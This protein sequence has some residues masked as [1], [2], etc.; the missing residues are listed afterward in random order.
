MRVVREGGTGVRL[1]EEGQKEGF[2]F[3]VDIW[4]Q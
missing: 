3:C 4:Q 2:E 1:S